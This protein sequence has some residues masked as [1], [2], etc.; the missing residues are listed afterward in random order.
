MARE[1]RQIRNKNILFFVVL[2]LFILFAWMNNSGSVAEAEVLASE[3]SSEEGTGVA[4]NRLEAIRQRGYIEVVT[5]PYFAP[6]E[7]IDSRKEGQEKYVGAEMELAKFIAQDLGVELRIVP[8]EFDAV[9]SGIS[10]GKYDLAISALAYT[11]A[12][13]EAMNMSTGFYIRSDSPGHGLIIR[14]EDAEEIKGVEDLADKTIVYQSG[15]LQQMFVEEQ[16][17]KVAEEKRVSSTN[18]TFLSVSEGKADA[19]A[20]PI[21]TATLYIEANPDSD[22]MIVEDFRFFQ[23]E[24]T[25]GQ[26][27]GIRKGEDEL[28]AYVNERIL[29][30]EKKGLLTK[31]YDEAVIQAKDLGLD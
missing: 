9:L 28:T 17:P 8:L 6:Y 14:K 31:W 7:F 4:G 22:L 27:I 13:I 5:E 2:G 3:E 15:S 20:I 21:G 18:D 19:A 23:D 26:R 24:K 16:V 10:T 30:A 29:E 12:R 11:P 25:A 1:R